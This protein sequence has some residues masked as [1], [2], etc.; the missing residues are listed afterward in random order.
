MS[1]ECV[2]H[3]K[4]PSL[5]LIRP[6][7]LVLQSVASATGDIM[8]GCGLFNMLILVY[9]DPACVAVV[10]AALPVLLSKYTETMQVSYLKMTM[11]PLPAF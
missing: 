8:R 3:L 7:G 11:L 10:N 1:V 2:G 4:E 9:T 5:R 6:S